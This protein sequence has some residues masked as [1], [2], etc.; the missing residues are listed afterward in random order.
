MMCVTFIHEASASICVLIATFKLVISRTGTTQDSV[1]FHR[2]F[3]SC[4][5]EYGGPS[6]L[7]VHFAME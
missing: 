3:V 2:L 7:Y 1:E 5:L 6:D 4:G